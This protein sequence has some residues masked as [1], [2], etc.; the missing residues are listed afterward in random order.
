MILY[1]TQE[2]PS[3]IL[4]HWWITK[5]IIATGDD[6]FSA[7]TRVTLL[8]YPGALVMMSLVL[9]EKLILDWNHKQTFFGQWYLT[10]ES[11]SDIPLHWYN[12]GYDELGAQS[13]ENTD[14]KI[15]S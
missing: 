9:M 2:S 15:K 11:P 13:D 14:S 12:H 3:D 8:R 5:I 6:D 1:L 7:D 10:L 4:V